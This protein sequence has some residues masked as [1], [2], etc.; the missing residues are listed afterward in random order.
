MVLLAIANRRSSERNK[1]ERMNHLLRGVGNAVATA[2]ILA[3]L[4]LLA[5]LYSDNIVS[6]VEDIFFYVLRQIGYFKNFLGL[7]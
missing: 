2:I 3:S 4:T 5:L 7:V 1:E 6:V